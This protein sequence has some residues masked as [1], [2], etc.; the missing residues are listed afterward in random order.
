MPA[1][2]AT[3]CDAEIG[4]NTYNRIRLAYNGIDKIGYQPAATDADPNPS[5]VE[6]KIFIDG[7]ATAVKTYE[8]EDAWYQATQNGADGKTLGEDEVIFIKETGE[9]IFG[10]KIAHTLAQNKSAINVSYVKTGFDAGEARPEYYYNCTM[11]TPDMAEPVTYTK[12]NQQINYII[13]NGITIPANTQASEVLDTSIGRDIG[14]MIDIVQ[15][16]INAHDKVEKL[17]QMMAREEYADPESQK[18]LQGYLDSAKKEADYADDNLKKTYQQYITNF[19]GYLEK[20]NVATTNVG[21]LQKRLALTKNRME[22]Q[23]S[24]V[25]ELKSNNDN[26]DIS[27][28]IIDY[29]AAYNAYTASL[30]AASKVGQQTLLNYL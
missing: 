25:E 3:A 16:A 7:T 2:A 22:N 13:S 6:D 15:T 8:N 29:Y 24:T 9:L 21:S 28:I 19:G 18:V 4:T 30:M 26:R 27:D 10:D 14:E 17:E 23:Q 20:V 11:Q 5:F 12:E 1:D